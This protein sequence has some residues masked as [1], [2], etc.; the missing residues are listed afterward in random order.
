MEIL[1][2]TEEMKKYLWRVSVH[3]MLRLFFSMYLLHYCATVCMVNKIFSKRDTV[4]SLESIH[5]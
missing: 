4:L 1:V 5:L 3:T 2:V